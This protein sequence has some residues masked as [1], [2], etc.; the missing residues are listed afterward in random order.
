M[1]TAAALAALG[2]SAGAGM[3]R[4]RPGFDA[5]DADGSGAITRQ[6]IE[7]AA[8]ARFGTLDADGDGLAS[9]AELLEGAQDQA[10]RR[11][12]RML[13]RLDS[14]G[15]GALSAD[16]LA[17]RRDPGRM[18]DRMDADSDGSISRAEFDA[19]RKAFGDRRGARSE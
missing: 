3:A 12:E 6:E 14:N 19:A 8:R 2:L 16:E 18:F 10:E 17:A 7:A 1:I 4:E 5:I 15:D 13:R 11:V 9:R